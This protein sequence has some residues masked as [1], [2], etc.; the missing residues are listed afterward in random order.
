[1]RA[2]RAE[3]SVEA[4]AYRKVTRR[5]IP[6]LFICYIGPSIVGW[7]RETTGQGDLGYVRSCC[8]DGDELR[9][10]AVTDEG[11]EAVPD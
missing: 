10:G 3:A 9:V 4:V 5:L 8:L 2:S 7:I 6:F 11:T 1:M